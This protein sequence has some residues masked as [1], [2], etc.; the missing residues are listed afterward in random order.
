[1]Q[2]PAAE[3]GGLARL[4]LVDAAPAEPA[5]SVDGA[6][7]APGLELSHWP[8]HR[9]PRELRH[10]LSTGCALRYAALPERERR[11]LAGGA[12]LAINNHYDTD[13]AL[14]LYALLHPSAALAAERALLDT[15]AAGDF[16]AFPSEAAFALDAAIGNL[17]DA[18]RSP[19]RAELAGL[20]G[21]ARHELCLAWLMR[22]LPRL[23]TGDLSAVRGLYEPELERAR[24][25]RALLARAQRDERRELEL[26]HWRVHAAPDAQPGR[27]ALWG[28]SRADAQ[29][30]SLASER[31]AHHR[32]LFG[33]RS[34]FDLPDRAA[35]PRPDL[36][37][38]AARLNALE[39]SDPHARFAWRCESPQS[40]SPE[41]WFGEREHEAFAEHNRALAPSRLAPELVAA[42]VER[43]RG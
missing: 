30:V 9:T 10:E 19:L 15:A 3:R 4:K 31:G 32:L 43:A 27:H 34:W 1:M 33:T 35:R 25:D 23:L 26:A 20:A 14:A 16:F 5:V 39:G 28:A 6:F 8:G 21:H 37:A 2:P 22:E 41:L 36:A 17:P 13:G 29:L 38:L 18:E 40:P 12:E 11:A 7:G 24:A 42:E